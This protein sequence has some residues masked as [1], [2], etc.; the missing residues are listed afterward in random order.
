M[1]QMFKICDN[2]YGYCAEITYIFW[3]FIPR[4]RNCFRSNKWTTAYM[5]WPTGIWSRLSDYNY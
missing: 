1:E 5:R 4:W 3:L 2:V